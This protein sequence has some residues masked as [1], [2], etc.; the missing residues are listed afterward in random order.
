M[1]FNKLFIFRQLDNPGPSVG[2]GE[3]GKEKV[4]KTLNVNSGR[5]KLDEDVGKGLVSSES[6]KTPEAIMS[7]LFPKYK[8][9]EIREILGKKY[10][11]LFGVLKG[12]IEVQKQ[13]FLG[14]KVT[15]NDILIIWKNGDKRENMSLKS[16]CG[17]ELNDIAA[18]LGEK[19]QWLL[20]RAERFMRNLEKR[21]LALSFLMST[22]LEEIEVKSIL[23]DNTNPYLIWFLNF[24]DNMPRNGFEYATNESKY[25][26]AFRMLPKQK[27]K[28]E[29]FYREKYVDFFLNWKRLIYPGLK[30]LSK[31]FDFKEKVLSLI[32]KK[33][34]VMEAVMVDILE[35][36]GVGR[37]K[38]AR[39]N[40]MFI[41]GENG[42]SVSGNKNLPPVQGDSDENF[43]ENY[44]ELE[45]L[46][47]DPN[48]KV[49]NRQR[50]ELI[51]ARIEGKITVSD[52]KNEL[53]KQLDLIAKK[54]LRV[55]PINERLMKMLPEIENYLEEGA[56]D[57]TEDK[58]GP[59][60][61]IL[62]LAKFFEFLDGKDPE[63]IKMME[64]LSDPDNDGVMKLYSET[65]MT[66]IFTKVIGAAL[67]RGKS[68][69]DIFHY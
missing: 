49:I 44:Y 22:G 16:V 35:G 29:I 46:L 27:G 18:F 8:E 67:K 2:S 47:V 33:N 36:F 5:E 41:R 26:L 6:F 54:D 50:E 51:N 14:F 31:G 59:T 3:S 37:E 43:G 45:D 66:I 48:L 20:D 60:G 4:R 11:I 30:K 21:Q 53:V 12:R 52:L 68:E 58:F 24:V 56:K 1:L 25:I 39:L 32:V 69:K 40:L 10:S 38:M 28:R 65:F 7:A 13:V 42:V 62:F 17:I 61:V 63:L 55:V 57:I 34:S 9:G 64:G 19:H 15:Y 23:A